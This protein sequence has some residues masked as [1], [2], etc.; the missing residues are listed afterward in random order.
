MNY[1]SPDMNKTL[2]LNWLAAFEVGW[3]GRHNTEIIATLVAIVLF[4]LVKY[5]ARKF[6]GKYGRLTHKTDAR[7]LQMRKVISIM[8]NIIFLI[9]LAIIWGVKGENLAIGMATIFTFLGVALFA[10]WSIISNVTAGIVIYFSAPFRLGD[11]ITII[12]KDIPINAV[13]ED[14]KTIYTHLRTE[15]GELVVIPNNLFLQKM[16]SVKND[17]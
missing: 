9:M 8:I 5:L 3:L 13:I 14:I 7:V 6:A 10:Q 11:N 16:V 1:Y 2:D 17:G 12:D 4:F 15:K